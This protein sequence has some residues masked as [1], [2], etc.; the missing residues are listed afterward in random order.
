M[1]MEIGRFKVGQLKRVALARGNERLWSK[2][3]LIYSSVS[4][5]NN[6]T[7]VDIAL[8]APEDIYL[9][10]IVCERC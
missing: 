2:G 5:V 7:R 4:I 10:S 3:R 1:D 9:G 8:N 6:K